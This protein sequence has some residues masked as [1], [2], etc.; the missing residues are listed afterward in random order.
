MPAMVNLLAVAP[1]SSGVAIASNL[2]AMASTL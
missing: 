1:T 2:M